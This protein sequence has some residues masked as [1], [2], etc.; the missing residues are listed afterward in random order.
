MTL[1]ESRK[2]EDHLASFSL[3]RARGTGKR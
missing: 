1:T 2:S 3:S